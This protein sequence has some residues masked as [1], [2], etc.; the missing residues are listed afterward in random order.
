[1]IGITLTTDQIRTAPADVR[2]WIVQKHAREIRRVTQRL[3][4]G[5]S[6]RNQRGKVVLAHYPI[7][8]RCVQAIVAEPFD[9]C[10]FVHR[11]AVAAAAGG[12]G[13]RGEGEG[14]KQQGSTDDAY[15]EPCAH[16]KAPPF[17]PHHDTTPL[18]RILTLTR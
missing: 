3:N 11:S 13:E 17:A 1:M 9:F 14:R 8:E 5:S 16:I 6:L 10:D 15:I 7:A 4:H 18:V 12:E 2:Q